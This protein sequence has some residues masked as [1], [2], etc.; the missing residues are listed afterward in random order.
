MDTNIRPLFISL[1]GNIGTGKSLISNFLLKN[2]YDVFSADTISHNLMKET[3]V[4]TDIKKLFGNEVFTNHDIDRKKI[5][6]IAFDN[7]NILAQLNQYMHIKILHKLQDI[8]DGYYIKKANHDVV[9]FEI[10]LLFECKLENS[11][12]LNVLT[13]SED[14]V[15]LERVSKRDKCSISEVQAIL[16]HQLSQE[17]KISKADIVL[18]NNHEIEALQL[19]LFVLIQSLKHIKK[20][21]LLKLI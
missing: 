1:T 18:Y 4:K 6:K 19:Q 2:C 17:I 7:P 15:L 3:Q 14:A 5:R 20:K 12:D 8:M 11:F 10:P 21:T 9:F 13:V 16:S